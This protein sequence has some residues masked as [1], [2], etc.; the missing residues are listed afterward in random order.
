MSVLAGCDINSLAAS[1]KCFNCLSLTEKEAL[2][3]YF[4]A[5]A[6]KAFGGTD[7]TDVATRKQAV[8]CLTCEPDFTLDSMEVAVWQKLASLS[9]ASN[10][11]LPISQLRAQIK[12]FPCG[13]QKST[14]ASWLR[15]LCELALISR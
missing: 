12:C 15:L 8:A 10:I 14:R 1:A 5:A 4:M 11:D 2:K 9:G 3:V 6:L 7:L 13:E